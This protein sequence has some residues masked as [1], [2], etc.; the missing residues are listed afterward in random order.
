MLEGLNE[1]MNVKC[2]IFYLDILSVQYV[3]ATATVVH[4]F[5]KYLLSVFVLV[6]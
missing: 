3:I 4:S 2:L 5:N 1:I 6:L